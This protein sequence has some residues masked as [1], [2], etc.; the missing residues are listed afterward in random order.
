LGIGAIALRIFS[1]LVKTWVLL[2]TPLPVFII[3]ILIPV[4]FISR[5]GAVTLGRL[6]EIIVIFTGVVL[7][8]YFVPI[9]EFD[10]LN[11]RPV[12]T[13]GLMPI[14]TAVPEAT[15][16]FLGFE[17]ML[18]FFPFMINRTKVLKVTLL[19]LAAVTLLY[20]GNVVLTIGVLGVEHT[21]VQIWPLMNYLRIGVLPFVQRVDNLVLFGWT[22]QVMSV[23]A[24]QYY[25]GTITLATLTKKHYHDIWA[26]LCWP[27][28][29]AVAL[30]PPDLVSVFAISDVLGRYGLVGVM[31]LTV[32]LL[33]V[34]RL[35]GLDESKEEKG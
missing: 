5:M 7:L 28:V 24:I 12:G 27:L 30:L 11:L 15:F 21:Q 4:V 10:L 20:A 3:G 34:A 19:A 6:M 13:E 25:A 26:L 16:A 14:L 32:L 17:V 23:V 1:E 31:S 35:R 29:Y 2:W 8:A 22:T 33:I 9:A 18:V